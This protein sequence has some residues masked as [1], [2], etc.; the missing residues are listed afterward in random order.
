MK[1]PKIRNIAITLSLMEL[2]SMNVNVL[3]NSEVLDK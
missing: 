2:L 1:K 3:A